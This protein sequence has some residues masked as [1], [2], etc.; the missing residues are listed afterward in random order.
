MVTLPKLT[1]RLVFSHEGLVHCYIDTVNFLDTSCPHLPPLISPSGKMCMCVLGGGGWSKP[2]WAITAIITA[3]LVTL[4]TNA[5]WKRL[6]HGSQVLNTATPPAEA[7]IPPAVPDPQ[8]L[9]SLFPPQAPLSGGKEEGA[10]GKGCCDYL[11]VKHRM[12]VTKG[13][14]FEPTSFQ[15]TIC[16]WTV[17]EFKQ[18]RQT[19]HRYRDVH[20]GFTKIHT[21]RRRDPEGAQSVLYHKWL[22]FNKMVYKGFL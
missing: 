19:K 6:I 14:F 8:Q 17:M 2:V 1:L 10:E 13:E 20:A 9:P 22:N 15:S 18:R 21:I 3:S 11:G 12:W 7:V 5:M 16:A 4:Q